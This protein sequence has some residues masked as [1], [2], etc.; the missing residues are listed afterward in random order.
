MICWEEKW[1]AFSDFFE[2]EMIFKKYIAA[3]AQAFLQLQLEDADCL[4]ISL[5]G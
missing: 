3:E 2:K 1:L 4:E 5:V